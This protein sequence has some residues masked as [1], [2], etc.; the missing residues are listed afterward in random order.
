MWEATAEARADATTAMV[1]ELWEDPARWPDWNEDIASAELDGQLAV[2]ATA[3]IRFRR[4]LPMTFTVTHFERER[5]FTDE[6]RLPGA[7]LGHEH[8]VEPSEGGVVIRNR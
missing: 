5:T 2:G 7:R 3:R 4:S 8:L 1:W 6:A